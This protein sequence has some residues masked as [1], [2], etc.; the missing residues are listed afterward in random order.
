MD[1]R[2]HKP[3]AIDEG[4]ARFWNPRTRDEILANV[5]IIS[6]WDDLDIPGLTD[7]ESEAFAAALDE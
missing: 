3:D 2:A 4:T 5:P 6:S 1:D 7:E